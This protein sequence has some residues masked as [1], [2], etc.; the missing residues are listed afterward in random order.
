VENYVSPTTRRVFIIKFKDEVARNAFIK[1]VE[2]NEQLVSKIHLLLGEVFPDIIAD[3]PLGNLDELKQLAPDA[4]FI[5]DFG[6]ELY[7]EKINIPSSIEFKVGDFVSI[8]KELKKQL[9]IT[10]SY[11]EE[12]KNKNEYGTFFAVT[13]RKLLPYINDIFQVLK[14]DLD[15]EN[16][17]TT[18]PVTIWLNPLGTREEI[19]ISVDRNGRVGEL[20]LLER[21][22]TSPTARR[23]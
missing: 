22:G 7:T 8:G 16:W 10:K 11:K 21:A 4:Q 20:P 9:E 3:V 15:S 14:I 17:I 6:N 12:L 2:R 23:V 13:K 5:L 19:S 1:N 18:H